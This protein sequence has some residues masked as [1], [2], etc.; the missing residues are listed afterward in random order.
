MDFDKKDNTLDAGYGKCPKCGSELK[1]E[2]IPMIPRGG[3]YIG[4]IR[5]HYCGNAKCDLYSVYI[6]K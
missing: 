1:N 4:D 2:L 6:N 3:A 5:L